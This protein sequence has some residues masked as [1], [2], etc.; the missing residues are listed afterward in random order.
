MK[1]TAFFLLILIYSCMNLYSQTLAEK[2]GFTRNDRVLII[3]NDDAGMCHA[4]NKATV[5]IKTS[6]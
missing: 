4:A 2:L 3:N 6:S 1:K 5:R